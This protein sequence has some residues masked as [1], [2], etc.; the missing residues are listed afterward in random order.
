MKR[1]SKCGLNLENDLR[2][3]C[4]RCMKI[5]CGFCFVF[6]EHIKENNKELLLI[7]NKCTIHKKDLSLYCLNCKQH[8]CIFCSENNDND[9]HIEHDIES[10]YNVIP[11]KK[12]INEIKDE[13]DKDKKLYEK[14]IYLLD[15]WILRISNKIDNYK[16]NIRDKISLLEKLVY[17]F[18][19]YFNNYTYYKNYEEIQKYIY[20]DHDI[21]NAE[22]LVEANNYQN[23]VQILNDIF[24]GENEKEISV[25]N[26]NIKQIYCLFN[27][28]VKKIER[29]D[30][31]N[32][33]T[34][35]SDDAVK[36]L[37]YNEK[38]GLSILE[39]TN[40]D[41]HN[42]IESVSISLK[43]NKIFACLSYEKIIKIFNIDLT[44]GI[45]ELN[46]NEIRGENQNDDMFI[47]C[48]ELPNGL[49]AAAGKNDKIISLWNL[50]NYSLVEK[51]TL[52]NNIGNLLL[53]NADYFIS[54]QPNSETLIFH[55]INNI[56]DK[57]IISNIYSANSI[58]CLTSNT[59]YILVCHRKGISV[60]SIMNKELIQFFEISSFYQSYDRCIKIDENNYIYNLYT[61]DTILRG[62]E[63]AYFDIYK[64]EKD[65]MVKI[66][67]G[68]QNLNHKNNDKNLN[69]HL[70]DNNKSSFIIEG[71][72]FICDKYNLDYLNY[73][74]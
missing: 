60:V 73:N 62:S 46:I 18:N 24:K 65:K 41:F 22:I 1:C 42:D 74:K 48:I 4:K 50:D 29:I 44:N 31:N 20:N 8:L 19:K 17:N 43:K 47:K 55:N 7:N 72:I 67:K 9:I 3:E 36:I 61:D 6:D 64:L 71:R 54:S 70:L 32:F 49:L 23:F 2:Y 39:N 68:S 15:E 10:L 38:E 63:N 56:N 35:F 26:M 25:Q 13:I 21:S 30:N 27:N 33:F 12:G 52:N 58:H 59:N 16:Q 57:K 5:Y 28:R 40:I 34:H 51:I 69:I 53:I 66:V 14:Y 37:N 45:M 11:S